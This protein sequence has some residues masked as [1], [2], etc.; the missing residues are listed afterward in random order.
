VYK[1]QNVLFV[2][3][4]YISLGILIAWQWIQIVLLASQEVLGPRWFVAE[5]WLPP[6]YDYHPILRE[7]E[8]G[9]TLP[10]GLSTPEDP[11]VPSSPTTERRESITSPTARRGSV[12]KASYKDK[13]KDDG[14]RVF[15]CAIC[16]QDLE[17]PVVNARSGQAA[18]SGLTGGGAT[19]LARRMYMV[20]PCRHIFHTGCLEG[21]MKYRLQ[22]PICRE[23]LP[24]L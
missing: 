19:L 8:E 4:D 7:D 1:R 16:M 9:S 2:E 21:W 17:V 6:A 11:K 12:P 3:R 20:T 23:G 14:K 5:S 15:D 13:D 24:P 18:E 10:L 22:C